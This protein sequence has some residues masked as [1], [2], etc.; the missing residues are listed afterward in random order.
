MA[1]FDP[2]L[3]SL[4]ADR[5]GDK[6]D[7]VLVRLLGHPE[8]PPFAFKNEPLPGTLNSTMRAAITH[9]PWC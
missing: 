9:P 6:P 3:N 1:G 7:P 2:I 8:M 5:R 4:S